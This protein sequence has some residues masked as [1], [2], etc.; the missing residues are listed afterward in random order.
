MTKQLGDDKHIQEFVANA[1]ECRAGDQPGRSRQ[2][3][4]L[5]EI[6]ER[7]NEA[8]EGCGS[9][10]LADTLLFE[11]VLLLAVLELLKNEMLF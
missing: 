2:K 3:S 10:G 4:Q 7:Q 1:R 6:A 5:A 11:F 8:G 9:G